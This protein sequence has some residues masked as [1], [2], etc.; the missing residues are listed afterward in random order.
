MRDKYRAWDGKMMHT[1]AELIWTQGGLTWYGPGVG[2]GTVI[3]N[4][5]F[6]YKVDSILMRFTG[7]CDKN[8][9]E[10]W[11]GDIYIYWQPLVEAGRQVYKEHRVVVVDDIP[12][13]YY[14]SNSAENGHGGVEVI[15]NIHENPELKE[16]EK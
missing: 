2:K 11:I 3:A 12:E 14:L 5:K 9:K 4:P 16:I 1:V 15:G 6:D 13:L 7:I 8:G 10:I